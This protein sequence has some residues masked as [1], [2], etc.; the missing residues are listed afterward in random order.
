[1]KDTARLRSFSISLPMILGCIVIATPAKTVYGMSVNQ[2]QAA[3]GEGYD[4]EQIKFDRNY[5]T[6]KTTTKRGDSR[7]GTSIPAQKGSPEGH[8][9]PG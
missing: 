4:T 3:A 9:R 1:M 8:K 7:S 2:L 5:L 6:E